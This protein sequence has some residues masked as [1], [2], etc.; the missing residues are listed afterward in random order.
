MIY[1]LEKYHNYSIVTMQTVWTYWI[2]NFVC[3]YQILKKK[4]CIIYMVF[5]SSMICR[6]S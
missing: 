2:G 4:N 6:P 5:M 3:F 1:D